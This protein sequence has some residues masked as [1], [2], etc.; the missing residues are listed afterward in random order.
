[1]NAGP[2]EGAVTAR[3]A[4]ISEAF[5]AN[6]LAWIL[7]GLLI[8]ALYGSYRTGATLTRICHL[9]GPSLEIRAVDEDLRNWQATSGAELEWTCS[10][11]ENCTLSDY[12]DGM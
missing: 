9:V 11:L 5:A 3:A 2:Q 7:F 1:M 8:L 12:L 6:P 4:W 10:E